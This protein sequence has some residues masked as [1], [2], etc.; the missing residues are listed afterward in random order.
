MCWVWR[1]S[2]SAEL[3]CFD[4]ERNPTAGL[5]VHTNQIVPAMSLLG[6]DL[7]KRVKRTHRFSLI[8]RPCAEN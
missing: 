7:V 5:P 1:L 4:D 8:T 2:R 3:G 6:G